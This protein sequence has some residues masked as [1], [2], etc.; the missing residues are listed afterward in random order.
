MRNRALPTLLLT[1]FMTICAPALAGGHPWYVDYTY[2]IDSLEKGEPER[3][4][5]TLRDLI[6]RNHVPRENMR[7]YGVWRMDY[8]PYYFLG[9]ALA[10]QG[11]VEEA[12][13]SFEV[14]LKFDV[15]QGDPA[16]M[17]EIDRVR[18]S[19]EPVVRR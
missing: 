5:V 2:A 17:A 6:Q 10:D 14:E 12:L 1:A 4:E 7:T 19:T 16:K 9:R 13:K 18:R 3:A 15:V 8:T 11:R